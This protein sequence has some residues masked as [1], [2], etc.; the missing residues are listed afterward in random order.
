VILFIAWSIY[1]LSISNPTNE[2]PSFSEAMAVDCA[3]AEVV[4]E[5]LA[6]TSIDL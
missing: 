1:P 5:G 6:G 2:T 4:P 3:S